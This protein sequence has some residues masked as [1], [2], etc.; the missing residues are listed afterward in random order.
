MLNSIRGKLLLP[1]YPSARNACMHF[2]LRWECRLSLSVICTE[3]SLWIRSV[4]L[5]KA[6][7]AALISS[8]STSDLFSIPLGKGW[9]AAFVI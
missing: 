1:G 8:S 7:G 5:E 6:D 3:P 9:K 4:E 2:T